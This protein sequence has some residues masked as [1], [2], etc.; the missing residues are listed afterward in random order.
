MSSQQAT[1]QR[2]SPMALFNDR[3]K[4]Y[5]NVCAPMVRYS[6]L[7]FRE[8]IRNYKVDLAYTPM[9]LAKEFKNSGV[10]RDSDFTTNRSDTS[11][12]IQ[13]AS[14]DG[15]ELLRAVEFV[16][17]YVDG[18]DINCGCPQKWAINEGI[19]VHLMEN[20][21]T[22]RDMI[23]TIKGGGLNIP[24][25]I[26]IRI[27][28]DLRKTVDFT[29]RAES[30]GLDFIAI[31]GRTRRQKS[32]SP[33]NIPAIKLCKESLN[34]PI[35]ANGDIFSLTDAEKLYES[36]KCDGVMSARGLLKNPALFA[37]FESTPWECI[38]KFVE[39]SLNYGTNHFIFHHHL[40][41]MFEDVMSN[42][43]RKTFNTLTSIP[44]IVDHLEEHYGLDL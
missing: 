4:S 8:L 2:T 30:I 9:I 24:I 14:N 36:T 25:S 29:K 35:I 6:K 39:L 22:V 41:Y 18:I 23:R 16:V 43:E 28:N 33:V 44:A 17:G 12:I 42:A 26:K 21:E 38:R 1:P 34:I 32:T 15:V 7:P 20:P 11:L 19:G 10:A 27:H 13:F 37:G 3:T 40:M 5:I 31:H